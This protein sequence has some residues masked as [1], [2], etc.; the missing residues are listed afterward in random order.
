MKTGGGKELAEHMFITGISG[1]GGRVTWCVA[2]GPQSGCGKTTTAMAGN[3]FVGD[4]L[5]QM[6]IDGSGSVRFAV[7]IRN[8]ASSESWRM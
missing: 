7:S 8:A 1:P 5:A 6:W 2:G 3:H 4:D